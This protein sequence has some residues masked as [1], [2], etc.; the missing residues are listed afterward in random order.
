MKEEVSD[1]GIALFVGVIVFNV[2]ADQ[3][4]K[5]DGV[6]GQHVH[7]I[8]ISGH[9]LGQRINVILGVVS[10]CQLPNLMSVLKESIISTIK[11]LL[12]SSYS[13]GSSWEGVLSYSF[14]S[15]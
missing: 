11:N 13:N 3:I 14:I 7:D 9:D 12:I 10:N 2:L 8:E 6:A 15:K 4:S 5:L 1:C